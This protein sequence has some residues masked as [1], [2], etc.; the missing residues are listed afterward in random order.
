[1]KRQAPIILQK[2]I[3]TNPAF[4]ATGTWAQRP[5]GTIVCF[6]GCTQ[7][8]GCDYI[9]LAGYEFIRALDGAPGNSWSGSTILVGKKATSDAAGVAQYHESGGTITE[10]SAAEFLGLKGEVLW[11]SWGWVNNGLSI[12]I[13]APVKGFREEGLIFVTGASAKSGAAPTVVVPGLTPLAT[14]NPSLSAFAIYRYP[15]GALPAAVWSLTASNFH[16]AAAA[17]IR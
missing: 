1:M 12:S 6:G 8:P 4:N 15:P 11:T 17:I 16:S 2:M 9:T 13:P 7:A 14:M 3:A 5:N 10:I